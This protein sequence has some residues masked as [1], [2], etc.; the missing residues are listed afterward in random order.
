MS[1]RRLSVLV[2]LA[3]AAMLFG[4]SFHASDDGVLHKLGDAVHLVSDFWLQ[5]NT[6]AFTGEQTAG[7]TVIGAGFPRT[8]TKSIE[9]GL[10]KL[11]H[12]VYD[13]RNMMQHGHTDRWIQAAEDWKVRGDLNQVKSL[14]EEMEAEGYTATLDMPMN[15]FALAFAELR[16]KAKVLFSVRDSE[17]KWLA[18]LQALL[19]IMGP[20]RSCRPWVWI[21]PNLD[22][23]TKLLKTLQDFD[24]VE[25]EFPTHLSRPLPWFEEIHT[26]PI[27]SPERQQAW[28]E[29]HKKFQKEL[30]AKLP[31]DR[32][33]VYNVKQGWAPLIPFLGIKDDALAKEDFPNI[34]D[35][36]TLKLVRKAMDLIA[37]AAPVWILMFLWILTRVLHAGIRLKFAIDDRR[38]K[39]KSE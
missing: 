39:V 17:E 18:S 6:Q 14:L 30:K 28:I 35:R 5:R 19:H 33:L 22:S 29:L 24:T 10:Q 11:G 23:A 25:M 16:P 7:L 32:L 8:G 13:M 36:N 1:A 27:D 20:L 34:N 37:F 3:S 15:L 26:N 31:R 21:F 38:M 12:R 2:A 4:P 9:K